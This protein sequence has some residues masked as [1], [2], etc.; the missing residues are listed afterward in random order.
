MSARSR[1]ANPAIYDDDSKIR[2]YRSDVGFGPVYKTARNGKFDFWKWD[3]DD[4]K[5]VPSRLTSV[6][7]SGAFGVSPVSEIGKEEAMEWTDGVE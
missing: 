4:K 5:W 6:E 3:L 1:R 2:Y 7:V